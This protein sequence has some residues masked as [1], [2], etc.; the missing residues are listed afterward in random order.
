MQ[1]DEKGRFKKN[2]VPI[3]IV[4][5]PF[6]SMIK[7]IVVAIIIYPWYYAITKRQF[8]DRAM[9][10]VFPMGANNCATPN[11]KN[12]NEAVFGINK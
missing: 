7:I 10:Y 12:P 3:S 1:R 4:L 9:N 11:P 5:P 8:V 2:D 6:W